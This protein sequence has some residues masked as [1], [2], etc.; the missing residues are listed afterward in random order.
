MTYYFFPLY[1][2]RTK[3]K[4]KKVK[5]SELSCD[6]PPT[7]S[8]DPDTSGASTRKKRPLPQLGQTHRSFKFDATNQ[9]QV[10]DRG[11]N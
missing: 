11:D 4:K 2:K 3:K 5:K 7:P 8:A 10:S 6:L 9:E 1:L